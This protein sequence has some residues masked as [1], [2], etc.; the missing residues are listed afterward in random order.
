VRLRLGKWEGPG[1]PR[2]GIGRCQGANIFLELQCRRSIKIVKGGRP[3]GERAGKW[4]K[5][6]G[7][8]WK[9]CREK[10]LLSSLPRIDKGFKE[11]DR[12]GGSGKLI[13]AEELVG[14]VIKIYLDLGGE[15]QN[16]RRAKK[17]G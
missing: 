15:S 1:E 4:A 16:Y 8:A 11:G 17:K 6:R 13:P 2:E 5:Q 7:R 10:P 3:G 9:L 14:R 12:H